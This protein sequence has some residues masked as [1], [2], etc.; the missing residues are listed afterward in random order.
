MV[1]H[2]NITVDLS[3][4]SRPPASHHPRSAARINR[5]L[6]N[7]SESACQA[8]VVDTN[9]RRWELTDTERS[10]DAEKVILHTRH[11]QPGFSESTSLPHDSGGGVAHILENFLCVTVCVVVP[12]TPRPHPAR[13]QR[14]QSVAAAPDEHGTTLAADMHT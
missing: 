6:R 10:R 1:S 4:P 11:T 5:S 12:E 13:P 2:R 3:P 14:T 7:K 8:L 9:W